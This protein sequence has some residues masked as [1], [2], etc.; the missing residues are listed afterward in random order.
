MHQFRAFEFEFAPIKFIFI[1]IQL[2]FW[3]FLSLQIWR[4]KTVTGM[5]NM[6]K[7]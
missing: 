1:K 5:Q 6:N 3:Q 7:S 2:Y 4:K